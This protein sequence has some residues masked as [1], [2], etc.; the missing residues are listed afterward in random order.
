MRVGERGVVEGRWCS[1]EM[2]EAVWY[3]LQVQR[4]LLR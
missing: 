2:V 1:E 4:G 3:D